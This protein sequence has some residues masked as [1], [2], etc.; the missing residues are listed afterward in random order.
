MPNEKNEQASFIRSNQRPSGNASEKISR[1]AAEIDRPVTTVFEEE[2]RLRRCGI[3]VRYCSSLDF[4]KLGF[5]I[6]ACFFLKPEKRFTENQ[7]SL[8]R[9][10]HVNN[11]QILEGSVL[12]L[13]VIFRRMEPFL[14]FMGQLPDKRLVYYMAEELKTE[15]A[16]LS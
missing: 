4:E 9:N 11:L 3:I 6:R 14:H 7:A 1:I 16:F 10:N 2:K 12:F 13:E 5:P 8:T 15:S